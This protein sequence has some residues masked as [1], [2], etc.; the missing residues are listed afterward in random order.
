VRNRNAGGLRA[1]RG[2]CSGRWGAK[3]RPHHASFRVSL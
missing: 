2:A 1:R 3:A